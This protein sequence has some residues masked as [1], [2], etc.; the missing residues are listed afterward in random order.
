M[1]GMFGASDPVPLAVPRNA[2][3]VKLTGANGTGK[4]R[5]FT[6]HISR[7]PRHACAAPSYARCTRSDSSA[8]CEGLV[9]RRLSE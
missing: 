1:D 4:M 9:H 3:R 2:V 7:K 5:M 6:N 8:F